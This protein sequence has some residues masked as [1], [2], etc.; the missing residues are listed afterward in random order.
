MK[1]LTKQQK[2]IAELKVKFLE[3]YSDMP[4][5]KYAAYSV[6]RN[7]DTILIWEKEDSDFSDKIKRAK[8]QYLLAKSKRLQPSFIIPLLFRELTPRQEL[9]GKDGKDLPTPIYGGKSTRKDV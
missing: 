2:E 9:T 5:K 1:K 7:E 4:I 3:Y 8:A 6:G